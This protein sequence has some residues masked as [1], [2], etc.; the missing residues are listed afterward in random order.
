MGSKGTSKVWIVGIGTILMSV[1]ATLPTPLL[2]IFA[3]PVTESLGQSIGSFTI[4]FSMIALGVLV[5]SLL[6]GKILKALPI[7]AV[8]II[9]GVFSASLM[10]SMGLSHNIIVLYVT[11]LLAG[12][13][14]ACSG[15]TVAQIILSKWF[16]KARATM[17]SLCLVGMT[18]GSA[19]LN[20][21]LASNIQKFGY[22]PVAF[23]YGL[24]TGIIIIL[25]A[26]FIVSDS[27]EKSGLKPYGYTENPENTAGKAA[28]NNA[29]PSSNSLS[30]SQIL[31]TPVFWIILAVSLL[32]T[33]AAGTFSSQKSNF[34]QSLGLDAISASYAIS[35][36]SIGGMFF[37]MLFG[38]LS[39]KKNP[40][41]AAIV[42]GGLAAVTYLL[43]F[44]WHGW[45]G[46]IIVAIFFVG[47][48]GVTSIY[49]PTMLTKLFGT[50]ES[51][52]MIG[53]ASASASCGQVIG[54]IVVGILFDM[55]QTY[56]LCYTIMGVVIVLAILLAISAGSRKTAEKIKEKESKATA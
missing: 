11:A 20:P 43:T 31:N 56:T 3:K 25:I 9:G 21:L 47:L 18:I 34:F 33:T 32:T 7:K 17:M 39:D 1:L 27:P 36:S 29:H 55:T 41:V 51:G 12:I 46:A 23:W 2:S 4:L 49:A 13:G 30:F 52:L 28:A 8:T 5:T 6:I 44:L 40:T 10:I 35:I 48:S 19:I 50:K 37:S 16:L 22:A 26:I 42:G 15:I 38:I 45:T 53:F 14:V 24:I 54:P